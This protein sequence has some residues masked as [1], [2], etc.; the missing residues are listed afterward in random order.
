[1]NDRLKQLYQSVILKHHKEPVHFEKNETAAYVLEAYNPLCGDKFQLFFEVRDGVV[2]DMSFYG[3]GCAISKASA[4]VLVKK[5][6]GQPVEEALALCRA[7]LAMLQAEQEQPETA[8]EEL[9]AFTA[10]RAF[11][12]RMKCATLSWE[13][14]EQFLVGLEGD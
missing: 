8:D 11:P 3:Y 7:F 9:A 6:E 4:S 14:M 5:M 13:E 2:A 10:A 1:M 12:G